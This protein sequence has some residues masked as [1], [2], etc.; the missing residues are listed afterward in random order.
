MR[1]LAVLHSPAGTGSDTTIRR[2]AG[3][4][5]D[6][7]HSV[8]FC[9]DPGTPEA[10]TRLA[11][12]HG[13]EALIGTHALLSGSLFVDT[14]LPYVLVFGGTDLNESVF[15]AESLTVMTAAVR[16]ASAL[17]AFNADFVRRCRALWPEVED[18]LHHV[19][20]GVS[21]EPEPGYSAR[22]ALDL[23]PGARLLLLP[24]GL[25]PVK[26]PLLLVDCVRSWHRE[27]PRIHLVIAGLSYN[28][29]FEGIVRRRAP[30]GSGVRYVGPLPRARLHATMRQSVATL[31]TSLSECSPN[32]ILEAMHLG[33]PVLVRDIPGNTCLVRHDVTGLVFDDPQ[34]FRDQVQRLLE[35]PALGARLGREAAAFAATEHG[36]R[37]E[38]QAYADVFG[39]VRPRPAGRERD[40]VV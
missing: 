31:N 39:T 32:A 27:D 29:D 36:L 25:R 4:L 1:I 8:L 14:G 5:R 28:A 15:D 3:H 11:R 7:G 17:I 40:K 12:S 13:V 26:D 6:A 20:Q 10:L 24:S 9:L 2:I 23:P 33:C 21:T 16:G 38:A 18:K 30:P 35:N 34:T 19:P 37:E 22:A